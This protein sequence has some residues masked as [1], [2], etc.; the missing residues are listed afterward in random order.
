ME[1]KYHDIEQNTDEW[2]QLRAGKITASN[3]KHI[4][5]NTMQTDK[6]T[7]EKFF[8][9]KAGL[10]E[11]AKK[12]ARKIAIEQITGKCIQDNYFNEH[13]EK[14]HIDEPI[15][16]ELYE[17]ETFTTVD[18]GGFV[19]NGVYGYSP[20]GLMLLNQKKYRASIEIKSRN[21][22]THFKNI[23]RGTIPPEDK[24][25]CIGGV[26]IAE[27]DFI[28]FISYCAD[29]PE[30]KKIFVFRGHKRDFSEEFSMIDKRVGEFLKLVSST[31]ETILNS[32]YFN[33]G[34]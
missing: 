20:D 13:M 18:Q 3:L 16:R 22:G 28:D 14:G 7:K 23:E 17:S 25:Q 6:K 24:W 9:P 30:G 33:Q 19:T 11:P 21:Y 8:N 31:K 32:E 10:G 29:F 4:M 15:A 2:L 1:M 26:M 12:Y 5:A 27:L 34:N